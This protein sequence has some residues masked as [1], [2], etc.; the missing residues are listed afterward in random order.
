M[1]IDIFSLFPDVFQPYLNISIL[2]RAIQ[3]GLIE[4]NTHNIRDWATDKH[5]T[6]D[7]TPYGGG[8][9][10][11]MKPEPLFAAVEA[12]LGT[13]PACPV[14]LLCPQGRPFTQ[15]IARE[16]AQHDQI[17]LICGRYEAFDERI[18]EHL[19]T[20]AI[21][22]GDYVLTGGELPALIVLDAVAR[23]QPGVLGDDEA[24]SD[25]S[26]AEH[27]I[28]EYPQYTKPAS[29]RGWGVPE[30]LMNGNVAEQ[31][32]WKRRQSLL[33][34]LKWRPDLLEKA[35]LTQKEKAFLEALKATEDSDTEP[36]TI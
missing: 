27:G 35:E 9:G 10:M 23:L 33:R 32:K 3:N 19:S 21:S 14:I 30:V 36:K 16:L 22:I 34:T 2:K 31:L 24:S 7:D 28:L 5:H 6:T 26:F 15:V 1:K 25:D 11:V 17:A 4:V 18:R 29:F 20:D 12:V 13:P 8:G